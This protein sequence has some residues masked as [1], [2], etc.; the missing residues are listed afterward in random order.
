MT[1]AA[2]ATGT[3]E[4]IEFI[5]QIATVSNDL[6]GWAEKQFINGR[7]LDSVKE[8]LRR[9]MR[10]VTPL[11]EAAEP[12]RDSVTATS[13]EFSLGWAEENPELFA[14]SVREFQRNTPITHW[15]HRVDFSRD[16]FV[17]F[18][19]Y[20]R[21]KPFGSVTDYLKSEKLYLREIGYAV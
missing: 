8:Q 21:P 13:V 19:A 16:R 6:A 17:T 15:S 3:H 9:V 2:D 7:S 11:R 20:R 4:Q 18:Y 14:Q 5:H 12:I 10:V 1:T